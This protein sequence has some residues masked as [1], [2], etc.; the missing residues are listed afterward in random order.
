MPFL[1]SMKSIERELKGEDVIYILITYL[2]TPPN[3]GEMKTKP[4][5]QAIRCKSH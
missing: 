1:F 3:I 5:Q 4:T 2:P